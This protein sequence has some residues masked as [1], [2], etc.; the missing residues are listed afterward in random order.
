MS[1]VDTNLP[2]VVTKSRFAQLT[3]VTPGRVSQWISERKLTGEALVGQGRSAQIRVPVALRQ[4]R[5]RLDVDQRLANGIE[6][7][8]D[9]APVSAGNGVEDGPTSEADR[10]EEQIK[11]ARLAALERQ[12]RKLAEDEALRAGRFVLTDDVET[13]L[14]RIMADLFQRFDVV[15]ADLA[16]D[17]APV[18][19]IPKR[20]LMQRMGGVY[21]NWRTRTAQEL[22]KHAASLPRLTEVELSENGT[23]VIEDRTANLEEVDDAQG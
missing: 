8:L 11:R 17:L 14:G 6:T 3:K 5:L 21:R 1:D 15:I 19:G 22:R 18:A 13:R 16:E 2:D 12:N 4:L 9:G 10:L 7:R 20:A 23:A